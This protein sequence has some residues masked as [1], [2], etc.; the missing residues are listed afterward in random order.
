[1][2]KRTAL[3]AKKTVSTKQTRI[4]KSY[5]LVEGNSN[6]FLLIFS[7]AAFVLFSLL[8]ILNSM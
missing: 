7:G 6:E 1:M 4:K 8:Y 2:K 3:K 5:N